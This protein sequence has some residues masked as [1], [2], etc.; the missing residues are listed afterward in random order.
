MPVSKI[1][2]GLFRCRSHGVSAFVFF[3][4]LQAAAGLFLLPRPNQLSLKWSTTRNQYK[5]SSHQRDPPNH[6]TRGCWC[7]SP[8]CLVR[9]GHDGFVHTDF[10]GKPLFCCAGSASRTQP[11]RGSKRF[12][13][14]R[15]TAIST[16]ESK[17]SAKRRTVVDRL[18]TALKASGHE[19]SITTTDAAGTT[20][21]DAADTTAT[22]A[23][24]ELEEYAASPGTDSA[25][26][27]ANGSSIGV[28]GD[29]GG[30]HEAV[31]K[32]SDTWGARFRS[33][34][35]RKSPRVTESTGSDDVMV[36]KGHKGLFTYDWE[37]G[38]RVKWVASKSGRAIVVSQTVV[39]REASMA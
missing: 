34:L 18:P 7:T 3:L 35:R 39:V 25:N 10:D 4:L 12:P 5:R 36:A 20:T 23:A 11:L 16:L 28:S 2:P 32:S 37:N 1:C 17:T 13:L 38:P 27:I 19:T 6:C 21:T 15:N 33:S 29:E 9:C 31:G 14:T 30:Q 26:D 22:D 24:V 8:S